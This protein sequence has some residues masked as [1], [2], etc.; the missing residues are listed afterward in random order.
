MKNCGDVLD[1]AT[2]AALAALSCR[3]PDGDL[4]IQ[5]PGTG[6][7]VVITV[8]VWAVQR[9]SAFLV[10]AGNRLIWGNNKLKSALRAH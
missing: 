3:S 2:H 7:A 9:D 1:A 6:L 4:G 10:I 5:E 8:R